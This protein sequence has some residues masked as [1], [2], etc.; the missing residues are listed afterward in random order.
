[1]VGRKEAETFGEHIELLRTVK[2]GHAD[3]DSLLTAAGSGK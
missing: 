1:M 3:P 2:L